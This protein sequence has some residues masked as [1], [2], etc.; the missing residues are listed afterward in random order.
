MT[1]FPSSFL[2]VCPIPVLDAVK[3]VWM[4]K[5]L[6]LDLFGDCQQVIILFEYQYLVINTFSSNEPL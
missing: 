5:L 2:F 3:A 6:L 4:L 1:L